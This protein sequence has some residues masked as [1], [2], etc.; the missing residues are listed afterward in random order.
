MKPGLT[1]ADANGANRVRKLTES[2]DNLVKQL[3]QLADK[4]SCIDNEIEQM[5]G[6]ES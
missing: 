3:D 4:I 2:R 5:E 6:A 1:L